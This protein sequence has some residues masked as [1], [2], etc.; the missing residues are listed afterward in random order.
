MIKRPTV[1][2]DFNDQ[3][4]FAFIV[5][6]RNIAYNV[7]A[8]SEA[9][10]LT[11]VKIDSWFGPRWHKFSGKVLGALGLRLTPLRVP[12]FIPSRVV[13]H[14][15]FKARG[16]KPTWERPHL[17]AWIDSESNLLRKFEDVSPDAPAIWFSG[18]TKASG[19][20]AVMV[21]ARDRLE[22]Y[23]WYSGWVKKD[24]TWL[25][26]QLRAIS[27]NEVRELASFPSSSGVVAI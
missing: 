3:D 19:R 23:G 5:I 13:S 14:W 17:H 9:R 18:N 10:A 20:G 7:W 24:D 15:T 12:P 2:V 26:T 22:T 8:R 21:Y 1:S 4:D 16:Y 25:P 27:R 6:A 11:I